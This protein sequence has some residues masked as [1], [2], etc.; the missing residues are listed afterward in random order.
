M[1]QSMTGYGRCQ[2]EQEGFSFACEIKTVNHRYAELSIRSP[3]FLNPV[4]SKIRRLILDRIPRGHIDVFI[5]AA[6]TGSGAKSVRLDK[7]LASAYHDSLQ[8]LRQLLDIPEGRVESDILFIA[9]QPDVL[10]TQEEEMDL[11]PLWPLIEKTVTTA[12]DHLETMR[13]TEGEML[14]RDI[15]KRIDAIE[16]DLETIEKRAPETLTVYRNRL[17]ESVRQL[18]QEAGAGNVDEGRLIAETAIYADKVN[19]TEEF[20]RLHSHL[21]QFRQLLMENK[22][23]GR[24]MDFL[25]QEMNRESNTIASKAADAPIIQTVVSMKSEIEKVREQIQNIQ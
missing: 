6:Y 4:E 7:A 19:T 18:L 9:G 10:V 8:G 1:L 25:V 22:P 24:R 23:V 3:R 2:V 12:L 13:Q 14:S 20:V 17:T 21:N 5:N 15:R 16:T 11:M